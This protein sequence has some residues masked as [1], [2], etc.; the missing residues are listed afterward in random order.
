VAAD[1]R[2]GRTLFWV[3]RRPSARQTGVMRNLLPALIASF[4]AIAAMAFAFSAQVDA[5]RARGELA[6]FRQQFEQRVATVEG[7][8]RQVADGPSNIKVQSDLRTLRNSTQEAFNAVG[9]ALTS[10]REDLDKKLPRP[11]P[12]QIP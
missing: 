6:A 9:A 11:N 4:L 2:I 3:F 5:S 8:L 1:E 7:S 10:L 12:S